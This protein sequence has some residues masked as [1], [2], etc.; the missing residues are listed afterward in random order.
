MAALSQKALVFWSSGKDSCLALYRTLQ[1]K[2]VEVMGLIS[3]LSK[4]TKRVGFHG[5][6][7]HLLEAQATSLG[8]PLT[9]VEIPES[10]PNKDY[11]AAIN[12][13]LSGK[14][15]DGITHVVFGDI[16]LKD[17]RKY[18]EN[19]ISPLG[20]SLSFPLWGENTKDLSQE[21]INLGFKALTCAIDP[22]R[23]S[24]NFLGKPF[25]ES[26]ISTLPRHVDPCGE[27]GEFHTFVHAGPLFKSPLKMELGSIHMT[28][29][30]HWIQLN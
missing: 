6:P 2:N 8:L 4:E 14:K 24:N 7:K 29:L 11:E 30:C 17:I 15:E 5:T 26:F 16:F 23:L 3:T 10:C 1:L 27:N 28:P 21:F 19:L 13:E 12:F 9:L 22:S 25:E 20:L 18:R